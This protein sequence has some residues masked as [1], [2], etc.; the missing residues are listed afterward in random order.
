M[1]H[2]V[3]IHVAKTLGAKTYQGDMNAVVQQVALE[4]HTEAVFVKIEE[5]TTTV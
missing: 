2:V 4:T 5:L 1:I 3:E